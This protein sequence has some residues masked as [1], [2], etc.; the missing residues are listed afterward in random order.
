MK[1]FCF[2]DLETTGLNPTDGGILELALI[3]TDN[4]LNELEVYEAIIHQSQYTLDGMNNWALESHTKSGLISQVKE[5]K[6]LT[7]DV[8]IKVLEILARHFSG[9]TKPI[10]AGSSVHFDKNWISHH[11]PNLNKRLHY[12]II[13]VTSF[14]EA[15]S[16]FAD[17]QLEG[18]PVAH[19]AL[20]DIR[21]SIYYLRHYMEKIK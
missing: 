11:M 4:K 8:E 14:K 10:I 15:M 12:R 5:S 6:L 16:I 13:D 17:F 2:V 18:R 1:K 3:I 21:D 7:R 9:P 19:R 20:A